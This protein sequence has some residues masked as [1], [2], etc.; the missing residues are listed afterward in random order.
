M[1][2]LN[3]ILILCVLFVFTMSCKTNKYSFLTKYPVKFLPH[4]D[5]T[6]FSN[7]VEGKLLT[8]KEQQKLGLE[9]VF[10]EQLGEK[11]AKIGVSYLP[12]ISDN[13]KSVVYY[14]YSS[15]TELTSVLVNYDEDFK[16]INNQMVAYD[17]IAD[18]VLRST[19]MI[20]KDKIV[21]K[22]YVA[23]NATII[24]FDILENGDITRE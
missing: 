5:S 4:I 3:K 20:Y 14:F 9:S 15:N 8:Q 18:G 13:F 12:K 10:G 11:G 21:L 22:E 2:K 7:H 1:M 6:N 19:A 17:E 24:K 16:I 23:D